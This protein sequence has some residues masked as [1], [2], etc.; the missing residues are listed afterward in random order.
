MLVGKVEDGWKMAI[1]T[2][3]SPLHVMDKFTLSVQ[4]ER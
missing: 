1:K 2:G 3:H 4:I